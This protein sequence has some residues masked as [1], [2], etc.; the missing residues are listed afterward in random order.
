MTTAT[1]EPTGALANV[2]LIKMT[3]AEAKAKLK[4]Y[5]ERLHKDSEELYRQCA[6]GYAADEGP[7]A[8][9]AR[10]RRSV[11]RPGGVGSDRARA[12]DSRG[13]R[14]GAVMKTATR[15]P[16]ITQMELLTATRSD[17]WHLDILVRDVE[18]L[19]LARAHRCGNNGVIATDAVRLLRALWHDYKRREGL[20]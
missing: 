6:A 7:D 12:G 16:E 5:R 1:H 15:R 20:F 3:A 9:R 11:G 18:E 13:A 14:G 19:V 4:A 8:P 10:R 17:V 2:P